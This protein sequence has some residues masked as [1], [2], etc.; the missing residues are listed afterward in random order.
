M[1]VNPHQTRRMFRPMRF[2]DFSVIKSERRIKWKV[3]DVN[4]PV[5]NL[6]WGLSKIPS[7]E[8]RVGRQEFPGNLPAEQAVKIG[9]VVNDC[10]FHI[11]LGLL[12]RGQPL[13]VKADVV[14][15]RQHVLTVE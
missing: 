14:V 15:V 6:Q 5:W 2:A 7:D 11:L 9:A 12:N 13:H 3:K 10:C 4:W 8:L 1:V